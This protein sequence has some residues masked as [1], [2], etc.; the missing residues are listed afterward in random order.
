MVIASGAKRSVFSLRREDLPALLRNDAGPVNTWISAGVQ[1][2]F[3]PGWGKIRPMSAT[4]FHRTRMT[5]QAYLSIGY[6]SYLL[7]V[8]GPLT[9]FLRDELSLSYTVASLHFSAYAAGTVLTGLVV[10]GMMRRFG[11]RATVWGGALGMSLGALLIVL[12][13]HPALTIGGALLMGLMGIIIVAVFQGALAEEHGE[14]RVNALTE[15]TALSSGTAA[16][17]PLAV[18]FFARTALTWRAALVLGM[19]MLAALWLVFR[20]DGMPGAAPRQPDPG[21]LPANRL[22]ASRLPAVRCHFFSGC[23]GPWRC[24]LSRSSSASSRG[25]PISSR[26]WWGWRRPT[27]RWAWG[28]SWAP[29]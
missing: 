27:R 14:Q 29:C 5:W 4:G 28:C 18:G 8:L 16:L 26:K 17:A 9:P 12:G 20:K 22:P 10:V 23:T 6:F 13:R 3:R 11:A 21:R 1:R 25:A 2:L 15:S 24:W 19:L 7:N